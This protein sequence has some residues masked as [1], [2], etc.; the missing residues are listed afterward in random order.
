[1]NNIKELTQK[2]LSISPYFNFHSSLFQN[3][4]FSKQLRQLRNT[5]SSTFG[6]RNKSTSSILKWIQ[7]FQFKSNCNFWILLEQYNPNLESKI[8][9]TQIF[10]TPSSMINLFLQ[11]R[12]IQL[13][14]HIE[15]IQIRTFNVQQILVNFYDQ[16]GLNL[17]MS[18]DIYIYQ[19]MLILSS[20]KRCFIKLT[21]LDRLIPLQILYPKFKQN[22]QLLRDIPSAFTKQYDST[23]VL[24][25]LVKILT[26]EEQKKIKA[27]KFD[28]QTLFN[29]GHYQW[30]RVINYSLLIPP[31]FT[32]AFYQA[33]SSLSI[34]LVIFAFFHILGSI[35][36]AFVRAVQGNRAKIDYEPLQISVFFNCCDIVLIKM[37]DSFDFINN[38]SL[39]FIVLHIRVLKD[40]QTTQESRRYLFWNVFG[41]IDYDVTLVSKISI[42][43][44]IDSSNLLLEGGIK[45][46]S[47]FCLINLVAFT[48]SVILIYSYTIQ[49]YM[50]MIVRLI[51]TLQAKKINKWQ[52]HLATWVISLLYALISLISFQ[53]SHCGVTLSSTAPFTFII[54]LL[55]FFAMAITTR[56]YIKQECE[57]NSTNKLQKE[58]QNFMQYITKLFIVQSIIMTS[59]ITFAMAAY[60][61]DQS[62]KL[63][64]NCTNATPITWLAYLGFFAQISAVV[65][66]IAIPLT[67][68]TD[69]FIKKHLIKH[70]FPSKS[71]TGSRDI[72]MIEQS[73]EG[74]SIQYKKISLDGLSQS[75]IEQNS[76]QVSQEFSTFR[77]PYTQSDYLR[78]NTVSVG[79]SRQ[80]TMQ[81]KQ[82][83]PF[84]HQLTNQLRSEIIKRIMALIL[85]QEHDKVKEISQNKQF[86]KILR[87]QAN[88]DYDDQIVFNV[89]DMFLKEHFREQFKVQNKKFKMISYAP[90]IFDILT[91]EDQE[92]LDLLNCLDLE[93][94]QE[95]IRECAQTSG[96]KSGEFFFFNH[97]NKIL[98][99][100]ISMSELQTL[101]EIIEQYFW[102]CTNNPNTL[103]A[104]I[105]GIFTF[106]GF[107][108]GRISMILMKNIGKI[109]KM[110]IQRIFD[111]K[112]SSYDREVIKTI[113]SSGE[114]NSQNVETISSGQ[115]LKDLDF[116]KLE[117]QIHISPELCTQ[118]YE[119]LEV[120]TLFLKSLGF[121]DYSLCL[122]IVD[123]QSFYQSQLSNEIQDEELIQK[124]I[125]QKLTRLQHCYPSTVQNGFYY[126]IG[127]I[128][129]LQKYNLQKI[130]EKYAKKFMKLDSNLD[131]SSQNPYEY[132]KRFLIFL[133]RI[134]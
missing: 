7:T 35:L 31:M 23:K 75:L 63:Q 133:K 114:F 125:G 108:I 54:L 6:I 50:H 41:R 120:D 29:K 91:K 45:K 101:L 11:A 115:V 37:M 17:S 60:L 128:D 38:R 104:K 126:H 132:R 48:F 69:P 84:I 70:Y 16:I 53:E 68:F 43:S 52:G 118:I 65:Y 19:F 90:V 123:W 5:S 111:L 86:K 34:I 92:H 83:D 82:E 88:Q 99:K 64:V 127:I 8:F 33:I 94:N 109:N 87:H 67:R 28:T 100:T 116:I 117:K 14:I 73:L 110:A 81:N 10:Q 98:L 40:Q 66:P 30:S 62:L 47:A 89:N 105:L 103:I 55:S 57:I 134:L 97:N 72:S 59:F 25:Q 1:M 95:Q 107:E 49:L 39:A 12:W 42:I 80:L 58:G 130:T 46:N 113:K 112:G 129:Y 106:E 2:L 122:M 24:I 61:L 4:L 124:I 77:K 74:T 13:L 56:Q 3:L 93:T 18:L 22:E 20:S 119:Q 76:F 102:H 15:S 78:T 71:L 44:I 26:R 21:F 51:F 27:L 9:T 96:G 32:N 121:M 131:T 85:I 79:R 36:L